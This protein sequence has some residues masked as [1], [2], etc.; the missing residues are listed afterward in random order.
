MR[1]DVVKVQG[2]YFADDAGKIDQ[3][4]VKD[5][6]YNAALPLHQ[7][8]TVSSPFNRHDSSQTSNSAHQLVLRELQFPSHSLK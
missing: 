4:V 7:V 5:E 8:L 6:Q 2:S 3:Y 1:C